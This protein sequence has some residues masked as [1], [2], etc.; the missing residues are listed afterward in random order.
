MVGGIF[1]ILDDIAMLMDDTAAAAK[2]SIKNTV[3]LLG[4]DLAVNAEKA[5]GYN[6]SRELP[7]LWEITKGSFLNKLIILPLAFLLSAFEP[8]IIGP[9]LVVGGLYLAYEGVEVI[10]HFI[11]S[12]INKHDDKKT[13]K[14]T[15]T[16]KQ[17]IKSAILTDFILSIEIVVVALGSVMNETIEIRVAAVV[18]IAVIA[19]VGVYGVVAILVRMDDVGYYIINHSKD[20]SMKKKAGE[21]LVASLPL[22]IKFLSVV[23]TIAM[24]LVSGS[25]ITHNLNIAHLFY[26]HYLS[27]IPIILFDLIISFLIGLLIVLVSKGFEKVYTTNTSK[28]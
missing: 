1:A 28:Q 7:V 19:T 24:L 21:L 11:S 17:K 14:P 26:E 5:S 15:L 16:E 22:V 12:K 13:T 23:G 4:D 10:L 27:F 6:A 25:L 8:W 20:A 3:P 2:V 9:I 18:F